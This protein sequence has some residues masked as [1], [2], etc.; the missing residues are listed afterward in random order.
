MRSICNVKGF[1]FFRIRKCIKIW[2]S[3]SRTEKE[4]EIKLFQRLNTC[5]WSKIK[6]THWDPFWVLI[7]KIITKSDA[8][9]WLTHP[10]S[11]RCLDWHLSCVVPS[12]W[13]LNRLFI[14]WNRFDSLHKSVPIW[15]PFTFQRSKKILSYFLF[16]G[17]R[18][19]Y[20]VQGGFY[21]LLHGV[22]FVCV[23]GFSLV[24]GRVGGFLVPLGARF[25]QRTIVTMSDA[26]WRKPVQRK[27]KLDKNAGEL[28]QGQVP[29]PSIQGQVSMPWYPG[30]TLPL[31]TPQGFRIS[32]SAICSEWSFSHLHIYCTSYSKHFCAALKMSS[33]STM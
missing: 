20:R 9:A 7:A 5:R 30:L 21:A 15:L 17:Q 2:H 23:G 8:L 10:F 32:P 18:E 29:C 22:Q 28:C 31:S 1:S 14:K 12:K 3:V 6:L 24:M 16:F 27:N 4:R 19:N 13:I 25:Q 26:V 33:Y 11:P